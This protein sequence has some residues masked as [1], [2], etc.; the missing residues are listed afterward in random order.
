MLITCKNCTAFFTRD[1]LT[2][3]KPPVHPWPLTAWG[4]RTLA[5]NVATGDDKWP[6]PTCG[7]G[8]LRPNQRAVAL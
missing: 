6:C 4:E 7:Q 8:T 2:R 3:L 1:E 5:E